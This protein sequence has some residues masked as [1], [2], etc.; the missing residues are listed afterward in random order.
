MVFYTV[1]AAA[2]MLWLSPRVPYADTWNFDTQLLA[3]PFPTNVL[4]VD[5][6]HAQ[7]LPRLLRWL[8]LTL[9][10]GNQWPTIVAGMLL[11]GM[12]VFLWSSA[13]PRRMKPGNRDDDRLIHAAWVLTGTV[14]LCWLGNGRTLAHG[15]EAIHSYL[16]IAC[17]LL[18]LRFAARPGKLRLAAAL[19]L[20]VLASLT[21]GTGAAVF[22]AIMVTL[23][24]RHA[25][26]PALLATIG[27]AALAAGLYLMLP[28]AIGGTGVMA[29]HP[30][31]QMTQLARWLGSPWLV[32]GGPFVDAS[33]VTRLPAPL[34]PLAAPLADLSTMLFGPAALAVWPEFGLGLCGIALLAILTWQRWRRE[35][36]PDSPETLALGC[37]WFALTCGV[38]V[39]LARSNA[40]VQLPDQIYA[41]RYAVWY[42]LFWCGLLGALLCRLHAAGRSHTALALAVITAI[43]LLPA[44]GWN[45]YRA[46]HMSRIAARDA[47]AL[48]VGVIDRNGDHGENWIQIMR[49]A[50]PW[51]L[52]AETSIFAPSQGPLPGS[53][54]NSAIPARPVHAL[55]WQAVDNALGGGG[56]RIR[57]SLDYPGANRLLLID[58][59]QRV[60]GEARRASG[61]QRWQG[62]AMGPAAPQHVLGVGIT[63]AV[64]NTIPTTGTQAR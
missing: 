4:M 15:N 61:K 29:L 20:A 32:A 9:W 19:A 22:A 16:I 42:T 35:Q 53:K 64:A 54:L 55:A 25:R 57:F 14:G 2:A 43:G 26:W 48:R 49:R 46:Q 51:L 12:C 27:T 5:N 17:L 3:N 13:H 7:I 10:H 34:Q 58:A 6:G 28:K 39:V 52:E 23:I 8:E 60:I 47:L 11:L 62:W 45:G 41:T 56:A 37:A 33:L 44:T 18:A 30:A 21:F 1:L 50:R 63:D 38:L 36:A 24:L 40:F 31:L 59:G